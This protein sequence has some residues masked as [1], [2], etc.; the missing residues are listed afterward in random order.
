MATRV[1]TVPSSFPASAERNF[2]CQENPGTSARETRQK[3]GSVA[4][5]LTV[6]PAATH[7]R[8]VPAL[9]AKTKARHETLDSLWPAKHRTKRTTWRRS[10]RLLMRRSAV[11]MLLHPWAR[12]GTSSG[13]AA[14]PQQV[15]PGRTFC[16][17]VLWVNDRCLYQ[18]LTV[19][20]APDISRHA[21]GPRIAMP[22][23]KL[24]S[25]PDTTA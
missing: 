16:G 9:S 13:Q 17:P 11:D 1:L 10:V 25:P 2:R 15:R 4:S 21:L 7:S 3:K 8:S 5:A 20:Q 19:F 23:N 18:R 14:F 22:K 6:E 24:K 12:I